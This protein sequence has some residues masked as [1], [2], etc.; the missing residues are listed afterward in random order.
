MNFRLMGM[1]FQICLT[2]GVA[3]GAAG[4]VVT[5]PAKTEPSKAEV[6]AARR[7]ERDRVHQT[8]VAT[9]SQLQAHV[10]ELQ[11]PK[12]E[13]KQTET[14]KQSVQAQLDA[15]RGEIDKR[16]KLIAQEKRHN[17]V[18]AAASSIPWFNPD[19]AIR[20]LLPLTQERDGRLYIPTTERVGTVDVSKEL[21]I[22]DAVKGL[23]K[24]KPYLVKATV[25]SGS[26]ASGGN[27]TGSAGT[28]LKT[29]ITKWSQVKENPVLLARL[30]AEDPQYAEALQQKYIAKQRK[31]L[32]Q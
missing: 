13:V 7:A 24:S 31:K 22:D 30:Q 17:A 12:I 26:G 19:D 2:A 9:V 1:A 14:E 6:K 4:V 8:L 29:E 23:A 21:S 11:K 15:L 16:D 32:G 25:Q 20:E 18:R 10:I 28:S 5:E 3:E 27:S